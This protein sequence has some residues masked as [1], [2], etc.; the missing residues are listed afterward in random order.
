MINT[1]TLLGRLVADPELRH[2]SNDTAVTSF[3][4]AVDAGWGEHKR[5]DF[6]DCVAWKNTAEF[7]CQYFAKGRKIAVTGSIQTRTYEDKQ[8]NKRKST[9][10]MVNSVDFADSKDA[11]SR[12][13][14][15][16]EVSVPSRP[17]AFSEP[18]GEDDQEGLS[19]YDL[20]FD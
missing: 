7:L 5:T 8:G 2:T 16:P 12:Q 6:I 17:A 9:E 11:G 20:L 10:I 13:G 19:E 14:S 18:Y 3:T 1:V 4:L 15:E